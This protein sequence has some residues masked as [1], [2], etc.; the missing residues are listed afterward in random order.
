MTNTCQNLK[1]SIKNKSFWRF[2]KMNDSMKCPRCKGR[3]ELKL[4]AHYQQTLQA[5]RLLGKPTIL[6]LRVKLGVNGLVPTAINKRVE[7]L[8]S[9]GVVKVFRNQRGAMRV[10]AV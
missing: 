5:I 8:A 2:E 1:L 7:R 3:G 6:E 10:S 9:L 4:A